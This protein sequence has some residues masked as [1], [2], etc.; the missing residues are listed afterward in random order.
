MSNVDNI[1]KLKVFAEDSREYGSVLCKFQEDIDN[2]PID[3]TARTVVKALISSALSKL[4]RLPN[5]LFIMAESMHLEDSKKD[6]W[7]DSIMKDL[8]K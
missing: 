1:E 2:M 3:D 6:E 4:I 7:L 8:N 5:L